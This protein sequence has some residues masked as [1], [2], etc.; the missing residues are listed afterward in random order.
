MTGLPVVTVLVPTRQE[1]SDIEDCL[2]AIAAQDHP[3]THLEVIVIDGCSTDGTADAARRALGRR[4]FRSA[5]VLSNE[6]AT[7]SSN[8]N[9]GLE[10]ATGE[11]VCRVDARTRIEPHYVRTCVGVLTA[12]PEVAVVGGAQIAIAR[13][14]T[15]RSVG[16]ARALNNRWSMGGSPYRRATTSGASD[17]VYLGAFRRVDLRAA[18]GWDDRLVSNQDFDLNQRMAGLGLVWFD[19]TLR[20]GYVPR[21]T[22]GELWRQYLRFG[23][24]KVVYWRTAGDRPNVRQRLLLA[25][26]AVSAPM[27]LAALWS[28]R[29][30]IPVVAVVVTSVAA[31]ES[32]GSKTPVGGVAAHALSAV[33]MLVVAVAWLSG[34]AREA[35]LRS[36]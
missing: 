14:E 1:V 29:T 17:T 5:A 35:V 27:G 33:A 31:V 9:V 10:H 4:V 16:I 15:A 3:V 25:L 19:A 13:D 20:S 2:A 30:R 36:G 26:P 23:R 18:G 32:I 11:I 8:L 28:P 12:R 22:F 7:A 21:A 34:V 24:A 6:G